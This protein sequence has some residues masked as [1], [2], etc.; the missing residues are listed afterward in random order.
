MSLKTILYL[1]YSCLESRVV[2][3][4]GRQ[5]ETI[6]SH[7]LYF[8]TQ[9]FLQHN[10][11]RLSPCRS[12][13]DPSIL[14]PKFSFSTKGYDV[15]TPSNPITPV[16]PLR[17]DNISLNYLFK[18]FILYYICYDTKLNKLLQRN[19]FSTFCEF[20]LSSWEFARVLIYLSLIVVWWQCCRNSAA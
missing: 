15:I 5:I 11:S 10:I 6:L 13:P 17:G 9:N 16:I 12:V 1:H 20:M 19:T 7:K 18:D 8:L 4:H 14:T 3:L 2:Y